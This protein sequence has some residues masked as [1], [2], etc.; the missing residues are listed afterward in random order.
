MKRIGVDESEDRRNRRS[1]SR[2]S[3]LDRI[4]VSSWIERLK[5]SAAAKTDVLESAVRDDA[6]ERRQII[7]RRRARL[8][9]AGECD[10]EI[11]TLVV[12]SIGRCPRIEGHAGSLASAK[13]VEA[14]LSSSTRTLLLL[15]PTGRGKSAAAT[16]AVVESPGANAWIAATE[17]RVG[18]WDDLRP[19]ALKASIL[20]VD[21]LGRES[22]DWATREW[23]DLLELRHNRGR[24]TIVTSNLTA[25]QLTS[26]YGER[27]ESRINDARFSV[28]VKALGADIRKR[29]KNAD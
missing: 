3:E 26:R 11:A 20:V 4:E 27:V 12:E 17:C 22:S 10:P 16:W 23:A 2:D 21:D 29:G 7:D 19:K 18:A 28:V 24:K 6:D 13:A 1:A 25:Q 15:G 14:F 8:H 9:A 5:A